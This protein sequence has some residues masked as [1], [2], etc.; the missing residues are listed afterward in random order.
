MRHLFSSLTMLTRASSVGFKF[1]L[2]PKSQ[3]SP[4][5]AGVSVIET[6]WISLITAEG[7]IVGQAL[8]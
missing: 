8:V 3:T 1:E 7:L 6:V 2:N 4:Y 5:N